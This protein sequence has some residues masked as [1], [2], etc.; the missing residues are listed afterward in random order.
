MTPRDI[1][2]SFDYLFPLR[3]MA[4]LIWSKAYHHARTLHYSSSLC[5]LSMLITK[6]LQLSN[7]S[8]PF[9]YTC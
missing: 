1:W 4:Y 3:I 7:I 2:V 9:V 8:F 5:V 6:S